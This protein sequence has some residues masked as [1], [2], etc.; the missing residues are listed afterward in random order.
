MAASEINCRT[1]AKMIAQ[2][3]QAVVGEINLELEMESG[4]LLMLV[5][6]VFYKDLGSVR[7]QDQKQKKLEV[8]MRTWTRMKEMF[9]KNDRKSC[10]SILLREQ[11]LVQTAPN[12][13]IA[14]AKKRPEKES[15]SEGESSSSSSSSS[16]A[17]PARKKKK[18]N[19]L[20]YKEVEVVPSQTVAQRTGPPDEVQPPSQSTQQPSQPNADEYSSDRENQPSERTTREVRQYQLE[21]A[22]R[23]ASDHRQTHI[24]NA[25]VLAALMV[26]EAA[27][28]LV[29]L[30]GK[31]DEMQQMFY[32]PD[33]EEVEKYVGK[34]DVD[35]LVSGV[36]ML[37]GEIHSLALSKRYNQGMIL[38]K[39]EEMAKKPGKLAQFGGSMKGVY[40]VLHFHESWANKLK[41][42]YLTLRY[43]PELRFS[44]QTMNTILV[45]A[46]MLGV[47]L[48][49]CSEQVYS[50][51][52]AE[53]AKQRL[54]R[55]PTDP[56]SE[57]F[58]ALTHEPADSP[59]VS[60]A[61]NLVE[62]QEKQP[63]ATRAKTKTAK[64]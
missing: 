22:D 56:N 57:R 47:Y 40:E 25:E 17:A 48:D 31:V 37:E 21:E 51:L 6:D 59:A 8:H 5:W 63:V 9:D 34:A 24:M 36:R 19:G 39:L 43:V 53:L 55:G 45:H 32:S 30:S 16:R 44:R 18:K 61:Q 58:L 11:G 49:R 10:D 20:V 42:L 14:G 3:K 54:L 28:E 62:L 46:G 35:T 52:D 2:K 4:K 15:S 29:P 38:C 26:E 7:Y 27:L 41:R 12:R 23:I 64:K 1:K 33:A 60:A 50:L 13:T